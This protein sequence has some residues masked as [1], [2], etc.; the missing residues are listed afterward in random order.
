MAYRPQPESPF[1]TSDDRRKAGR[2]LNSPAMNAERSEL[3]AMLSAG[4]IGRFEQESLG[5]PLPAWP[6]YS[7][8]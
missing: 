2:L 1:L 8:E 4:R 5:I 3:E 7:T 6:F